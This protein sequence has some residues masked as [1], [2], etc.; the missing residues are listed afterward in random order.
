[1]CN[2]AM[3][4]IENMDNLKYKKGDQVISLNR[5]FYLQPP[6]VLTGVPVPPL[7]ETITDVNA[8]YCK[9]G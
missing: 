3:G 7:V 5:F 9:I 4:Y 8:E 2:L 6:E 1:M